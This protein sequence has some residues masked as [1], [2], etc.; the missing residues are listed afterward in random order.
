MIPIYIISLV[1]D[2]DK[3]N[4]ISKKL[5]DLNLEYQ[6]I[7]AIHGKSLSQDFINK[8]SYKG[9]LLTRGYLATPGEIGCTLSHLKAYKLILKNNNKWTCILE[10]DAILDENFS[11]FIKNFNNEVKNLDKDN[12]YILG[13]QDGIEKTKY[14][15]RSI[16][17]KQYIGKQKF[18]KTIKSEEFIF[19]TCC[20]VISKNTANNLAT[21]L[22]S[23]FYL[24]DDWLN[25]RKL[26]LFTNI[27]I[28]DIVHHPLD[29][30]NSAIEHERLHAISNRA[31]KSSSKIKSLLKNLDFINVRQHIFSYAKSTLSQLK[32]L[33]F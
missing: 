26:K 16:W 22:E 4:I 9:K 8:L 33:Y 28:A 23:N 5:N 11:T 25:Y 12:L 19:R 10:D 3:R 30:S 32:R 29:L 6:F 7:D 20:Y 1:N 31:L 24:A 27:Y 18:Y 14:I 15:S 13:G 17:S 2:I 21:T